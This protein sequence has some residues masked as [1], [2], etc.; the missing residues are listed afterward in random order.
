MGTRREALFAVVLSAGT[1]VL[2]AD[3]GVLGASACVLGAS[4]CVLSAST[5]V[6]SGG[7]RAHVFRVFLAE[8][9]A[10]V[11]IIGQQCFSLKRRRQSIN[12]STAGKES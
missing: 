1:G 7:L 8:G 3:A 9:L 4:T 5:R 10:F 12:V 6:L 11:A 2:C